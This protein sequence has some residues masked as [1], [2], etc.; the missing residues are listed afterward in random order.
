MIRPYRGI[1][2]G[3]EDNG[4]GTPNK[5]VNDADALSQY[6]EWV[7]VPALGPGEESPSLSVTFFKKA[8]IPLGTNPNPDITFASETAGSQV[9]PTTAPASK[10][11]N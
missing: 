7:S 10:H 5:I 3:D 8:G 2:T 4:H 9:A 11:D 1:K 6:G